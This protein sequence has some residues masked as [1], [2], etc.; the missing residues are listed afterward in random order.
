MTAPVAPPQEHRRRLGLMLATAVGVV[1]IAIVLLHAAALRSDLARRRSVLLE[2]LGRL[3]EA[4]EDAFA[5]DGHYAAHLEASGGT[6]T[7]RFVPAPDVK[8]RFELL[9]PATWRAIVTDTAMSAGPRNCGD[10]RGDSAAAP[11]RA[12]VRPGV[13]ACW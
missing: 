10:F 11:H 9:G 6:D 8:V 1:L 13:P 12:V 7:A 4:Q 3:G 5:R 2:T